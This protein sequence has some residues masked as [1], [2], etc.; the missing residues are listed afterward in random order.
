MPLH[1][2]QAQSLPSG[3][4]PVF[5]TQTTSESIMQ[6]DAMARDK[7]AGGGRAGEYASGSTE[8]AA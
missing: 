3:A 1:K 5:H 4:V 7:D 8:P 2:D 6:S